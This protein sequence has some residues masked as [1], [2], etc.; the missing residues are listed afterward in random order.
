MS[1]HYEHAHCSLSWLSPKYTVLLPQMLTRAP[2]VDWSNS[3]CL[4]NVCIFYLFFFLKIYS[5]GL[6]AESH[7]WGTIR[8][9]ANLNSYTCFIFQALHRVN[10]R[11]LEQNPAESLLFDVILITTDSQQQQQSSRIISS[12]RHYGN[13]TLTIICSTKH[14]VN[15]T[16]SIVS[17]PRHYGNLT[18]TSSSST[19]HYGNLTLTFRRQIT[20]SSWSVLEFAGLLVTALLTSCYDV[21][22]TLVYRPRCRQVLFCQRGGFHWEFTEK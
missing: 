7:R 9:P 12:T 18:L 17:S 1:L 22:A 4:I 2:D 20:V 8:T 15:L 13:L 3:S 21:I 6:G 11:L 16:L 19:R 10:E 5:K 14:Y